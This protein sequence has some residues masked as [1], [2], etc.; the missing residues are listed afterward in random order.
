M[1]YRDGSL[2]E[3]TDE[4]M[5]ASMLTHESSCRTRLEAY[6]EQRADWGQI[7]HEVDL[8]LLRCSPELIYGIT[9]REPVALARSLVVYEGFEM[10]ALAAYLRS[11]WTT[12]AP[13]SRRGFDIKLL[14]NFAVRMLTGA[15]GA[16]ARLGA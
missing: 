9:L 12:P 4:A 15:T 16:A 5:K 2:R 13:Q 10:E 11:P 1:S 7:E 8:R 3:S 14:D 6:A